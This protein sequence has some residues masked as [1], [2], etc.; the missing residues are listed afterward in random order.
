MQG[1]TGT[2]LVGLALVDEK[3]RARA[4]AHEERIPKWSNAML[5]ET[6]RASP[7]VS[8]NPFTFNSTR[9]KQK[10]KRGRK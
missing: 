2:S 6:R 5:A 4:V 8:W 9:K 7:R 1:E 10:E 3:W